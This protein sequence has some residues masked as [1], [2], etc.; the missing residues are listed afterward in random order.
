[1][2]SEKLKT[3]FLMQLMVEIT[4]CCYPILADHINVKYVFISPTLPFYQ[5]SWTQ[6]NYITVPSQEERRF[7]KIIL[8]CNFCKPLERFLPVALAHMIHSVL[9]HCFLSTTF[10]FYVVVSFDFQYLSL[11]LVISSFR[12]VFSRFARQNV[13]QRM[14]PSQGL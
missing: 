4:I 5:A 10:P 1:M 3:K 7:T 6:L 13:Y 2:N 8:Q 11:S 14:S 9:L 12:S